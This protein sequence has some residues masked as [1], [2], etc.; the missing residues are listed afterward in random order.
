M[1]IHNHSSRDMAIQF[2]SDLA[3]ALQTPR[4]ES[5][6]QVGYSQ[7][8]AIRGLAKLFDA[9]NKI[10]NRDELPTPPD[11]LMKNITKLP[12]AEDQTT[13]PPRVDTDDESKER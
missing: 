4:S 1:E 6:F 8:K 7:L 12:R 2:A 9:E 3:K 5:N 11:S 10:P 13:P